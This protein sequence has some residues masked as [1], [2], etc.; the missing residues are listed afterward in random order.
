MVI[1]YDQLKGIHSLM[2]ILAEAAKYEADH[3]NKKFVRPSRLP[4]YDKNIADNATTVIQVRAEVAHKSR[5]DDYASYEAAECG[6]STF[7][8]NVIDEIWYNDLKDAET[9]YTRVLAIDIMA[10]LNANSGGLHALDMISLHTN[11]TQYYAEADGIPQFIVMMEDAQK[12]AKRVGMPI[13]DV[14]LVMMASTAVLVAQ[15][16]PREVDD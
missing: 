14:E 3:G 9:F 7:L 13:A 1:D 10:H 2:A 12:K 8:R 4:L 6:V 16:F 15:H 5:L 11:M